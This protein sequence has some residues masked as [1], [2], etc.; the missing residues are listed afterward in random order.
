MHRAA[1]VITSWDDADKHTFKLCL[2]LERYKIRGTFFIPLVALRKGWIS[3]EQLRSLSEIQEIG[4][5]TVTHVDLTQLNDTFLSEE[6]K[7]SKLILEEIIG[8][9]V[10]S[11]CYPGGHYNA[12]VIQFVKRAGY[13]CARTRIKYS[14]ENYQNPFRIKT[15]LQAGRQRLFSVQTMRALRLLKLGSRLLVGDWVKLGKYNFEVAL[16]RGGVY[17]L[18]GHAWEIEERNEWDKLEDLLAYIANR[19]SVVYMTLG[20]YVSF[21]RE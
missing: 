3:K 15:T 12:R 21:S 11:F 4:S 8:K 10:A 5:H 1:I 20:Q 13:R 18:W 2:L 19:P 7:H 9:P 17:H 6:I 16:A 14:L